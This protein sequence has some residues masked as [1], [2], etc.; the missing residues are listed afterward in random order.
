MS[1]NMEKWLF[2]LVAMAWLG[3]YCMGGYGVYRDKTL[4]NLEVKNVLQM[5]S[6]IFIFALD[7][8]MDPF[9]AKSWT[10]PDSIKNVYDDTTKIR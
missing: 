10:L 7:K 5:T 2:F 9:W 4:Y 1:E 6:K 3:E 8:I